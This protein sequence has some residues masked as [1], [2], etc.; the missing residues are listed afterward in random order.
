LASGLGLTGQPGEWQNGRWQ[1]AAPLHAFRSTTPD[2]LDLLLVDDS[3]ATPQ[4]WTVAL[5][6]QGNWPAVASTPLPAVAVVPK[7][8]ND[9]GL[10]TSLPPAS[11][12]AL[13]SA[14]LGAFVGGLLLNLM[15]CVLP[16]LAIKLLSLSQPAVTAR[17]RRGIGLAYTLGVL[18][19]MIGLALLVMVVRASGEQLGWGFQLQSPWVV[20]ALSL[21]FTLI[22][23]NLFGVLQVRAA[24]ASGLAAQMA[25]HPLADAL[26]SGVLAVVVAAP[27]TAPIMVASVG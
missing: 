2:R 10:D 13:V 20:I 22:A 5:K 14:L 19:S 12:W 6:I 27:C 21:L 11:A 3:H 24:W 23:L 4:A 7:P 15:P 1:L 18:I 16:V 17:M 8:T 26:L 25:R 9:S